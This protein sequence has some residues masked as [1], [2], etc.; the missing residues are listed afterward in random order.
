MRKLRRVITV[1]ALT[2]LLWDTSRAEVIDRILAVVDRELITM[3]D[4][5]AAQRLGLAAQPP[6]GNDPIRHTL[7][8]LIER[9]LELA[10]ANRY[11]PPEPTA[12]QIQDALATVSSRFRTAQE[13]EEALAQTGLTPEQLRLRVRDDLR[14]EAYLNQRFGAAIQPSEQ[15]VVAYYRTHGAELSTAAG[16]PP[17][18]DVRQAIRSRLA[19]AR[20]A[21]LATEWLEGLRRRT[22][23]AD[24]YVSPD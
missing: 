1:G 15:E 2:L 14:I 17:L 8:A 6:A 20:R 21:S 22:E 11:M 16:V 7:D 3:S 23:I 18:D 10:E 24:L 9:Q 12:A 19:A 13:L 5:V 4:V